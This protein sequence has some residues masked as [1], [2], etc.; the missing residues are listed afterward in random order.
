MSEIPTPKDGGRS[1]AQCGEKWGGHRGHEYVDPP[2]RRE[3]ARGERKFGERTLRE[4]LAT[5]QPPESPR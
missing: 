4:A 2:T 5:S 3:M 1:C